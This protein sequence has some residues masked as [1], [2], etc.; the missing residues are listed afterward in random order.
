M[1][2]PPLSRPVPTAEDGPAVTVGGVGLR[3]SELLGASTAVAERL[4]GLGVRGPLAVWAGPELSTVV[5]L[6]GALRA[7]VPVVPV[8]PGDVAA[9]KDVQA[10]LGGP[11]DVVGAGSGLPTVP[12]R[13]HARGWHHIP[14][15]PLDAVALVS[16]DVPFTRRAMADYTDGVAAGWGWTD[17]DT[18][19]SALPLSGAT[20]L[21]LGLVAPMR[22]GS[23]LVHVAEGRLPAGSLYLGD[24]SFY[25]WAAADPLAVQALQE[26]RV[27]VST[28]AVPLTVAQQVRDRTGHDVAVAPG[29]TDPA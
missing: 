23:A 11:P 5:G 18:V 16:G 4:L 29:L 27:L 9:A 21:A 1:L 25:T 3:R 2:F 17:A 6:V 10:W 7:G 19:V 12:V 14:E 8:G 26:A 20:A 15:P 22:V 13:V 28:D 24:A